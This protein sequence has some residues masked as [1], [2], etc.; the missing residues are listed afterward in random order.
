MFS[1]KVDQFLENLITFDKEN[2]A[3]PN[4]KAIRPYLDNSEF[5]PEFIRSKSAAAAGVFLHT[6]ATGQIDI[7]LVPVAIL[8]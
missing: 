2:I 3:D 8:R 1:I 6:V 5:D 7:Q 4:L